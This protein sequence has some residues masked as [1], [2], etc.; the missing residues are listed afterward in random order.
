MREA[1]EKKNKA[2]Y[3]QI[4]LQLAKIKTGFENL[5]EENYKENLN[6]I[7]DECHKCLQESAEF[8]FA[9]LD[10]EINE[11]L[12]LAYGE[13]AED[14]GETS[15]VN[16]RRYLQNSIARGKAVSIKEMS[17]KPAAFARLCLQ[18]IGELDDS[19]QDEKSINKY[20]AF[21]N[22]RA[23][24]HF[25]LAAQFLE[26]ANENNLLPEIHW[27][28]LNCYNR[29]DAIRLSLGEVMPARVEERI[30]QA[31]RA[32]EHFLP[33]GS[34]KQLAEIEATLGN[35]FII[36]NSGNRYENREIAFNFWFS[37]VESV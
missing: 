26:E 2:R 31:Q 14:D 15:R 16:A 37:A 6:L 4:K 29:S 18:K 27:Q 8:D 23:L 25:K 20:A 19:G 35:L 7:I 33:F 10:G 24:R 9:E 13:R 34:T 28:I 17:E 3:R 21:A 30:L 1:D 32:R 22:E 36:R 11:L 5:A 12:G